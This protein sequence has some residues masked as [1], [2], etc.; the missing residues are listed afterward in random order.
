MAVYSNGKNLGTNL[1][2][3]L[4]TQHTKGG[5]FYSYSC[6]HVGQR[7]SGTCLHLVGETLQQIDR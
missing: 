7:V 4:V 2:E 6:W 5:V 3:L 1:S